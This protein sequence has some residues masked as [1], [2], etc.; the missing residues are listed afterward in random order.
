MQLPVLKGGV[1]EGGKQGP[2]K[3]LQDRVAE[4]GFLQAK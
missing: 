3:N 1:K 4:E 2:T